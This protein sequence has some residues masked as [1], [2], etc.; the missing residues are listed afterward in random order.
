MVC[1]KAVQGEKSETTG[2]FMKEVSFKPRVKDR[3]SY[4][5]IKKEEVM[6]KE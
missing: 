3:G 6:R 4:G 2:G 1:V 5:N